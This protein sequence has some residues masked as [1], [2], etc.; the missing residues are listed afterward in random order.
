[1][2]NCT[3]WLWSAGKSVALC[4]N[5]LY[6]VR[7]QTKYE[8]FMWVPSITA[9]TTDRWLANLELISHTRELFSGLAPT[10]PTGFILNLGTPINFHPERVHR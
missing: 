3:S 5:I 4:L 8:V 1:M 2:C 7:Q 9:L 10:Q 6:T